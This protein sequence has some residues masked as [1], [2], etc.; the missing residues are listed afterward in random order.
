MKI[1]RAAARAFRAATAGFRLHHRQ[2]RSEAEIGRERIGRF[3]RNRRSSAASSSAV[4]NRSFGSLA[5]ALRTIVSRSR[6]M[7]WSSCRGGAGGSCTTWSINREPVRTFK[8][9]AQRQQLVQGR[10]QGVDVAPAVRDAP[11]P[12]GGHVPQGPDHV[13]RLRQVLPLLEFRQAEVGNPDIAD[14]IQEQVRRLDVAVQH[15]A[16]VGVRQG[17]GH[18][19]AQAGD[20]A[21]IAVLALTGQRRG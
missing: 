17:V 1:V 2:S 16:L 5:S 19:G 11:E 8:H 6:G 14:R 21:V 7:R 4:A 18:L 15:A 12:L 13:L 20:L 9:R 3:S 10:A